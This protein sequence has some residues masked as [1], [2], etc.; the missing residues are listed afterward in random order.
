MKDHIILGSGADSF[1]F[2]Y[3]QND[4]IGRFNN[5]YSTQI[6]TKPHNLFLQIGIQTGLLSLIAF[7]L[8]YAIY[9]VSSIKLYM[10]NIFD[11]YMSQ[12][13]AAIF[14]GTIGYMTAG[15]FNDSTI[16]VSPVFWSLIGIGLAVNYQLKLVR[17]KV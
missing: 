3:P 9:F 12:L 16:T 5:G 1:I 15:L 8:F 14:V 17:Q 10:N 13:G 2:D 6:V 11:T 7:L 4:Y